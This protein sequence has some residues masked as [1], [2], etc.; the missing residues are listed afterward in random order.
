MSAK[1]IIN[2]ET[3]QPHENAMPALHNIAN[4]ILAHLAHGKAGDAKQFAMVQQLP[5]IALGF[6]AACLFNQGIA[7][8]DIEAVLLH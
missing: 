3:G 5:P 2:N 8:K 4:T 6:L 1:L 7:E